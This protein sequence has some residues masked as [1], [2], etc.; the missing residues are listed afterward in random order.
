V[1]IAWGVSS[2]HRLYNLIWFNNGYHAEHHFRPK[3]HWTEMHALHERIKEEQARAKVRVI[4]PPHALGFLDPDLPKMGRSSHPDA[5][6][7][8]S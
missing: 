7:S 8:V 2:Y 4:K 3:Q 6:P 1:P 5:A